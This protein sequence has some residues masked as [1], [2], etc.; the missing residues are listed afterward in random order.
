MIEVK[1]EKIWEQ[2]FAVGD[3]DR[4]SAIKEMAEL[5]GVSPLFAVLLYNR[6]Y[7]TAE[8]ARRFLRFEETDFHDPYLMK[9]MNM[10]V[11]RIISAVENK[12]KIYVYGDYDV[13]GVTSSAMLY[14]YLTSIGA[15]VG[16]KIPKRDGEGYGVSR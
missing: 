5:L 16:I 10:A 2:R 6:G 3:L 15:E 9:D 8:S 4:D 1:R 13:D 12:E 14:L 11:D 7:T